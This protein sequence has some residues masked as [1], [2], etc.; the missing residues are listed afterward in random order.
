MEKFWKYVP[1]S[2]TGTSSA[3][4]KKPA[5]YSAAMR[6]SGLRESLPAISSDA[7]KARCP[8]RAD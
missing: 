8:F 3:L 5:I 2:P 6:P 7:R 4:R 1:L